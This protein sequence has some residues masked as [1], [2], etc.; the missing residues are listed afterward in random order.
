MTNR[1]AKNYRPTCVQFFPLYICPAL[2]ATEHLS[3]KAEGQ[4]L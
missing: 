1:K 3:R 4:A 2:R